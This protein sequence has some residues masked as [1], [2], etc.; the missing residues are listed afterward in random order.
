MIHTYLRQEK[1]P[2]KA[3]LVAGSKDRL[4]DFA[5]FISQFISQYENKDKDFYR[6]DFRRRFLW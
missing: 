3:F 6:L 2:A 4:V 5:T 1:V